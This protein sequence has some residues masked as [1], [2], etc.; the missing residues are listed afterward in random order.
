MPVSSA[1]GFHGVVVNLLVTDIKPESERLGDNLK[2]PY[3]NPATL[4]NFNTVH[5]RACTYLF[6]RYF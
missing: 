6:A 2:Q 3:H 1:E 5:S 4:S